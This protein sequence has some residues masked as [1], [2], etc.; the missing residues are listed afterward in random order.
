MANAEF[1]ILSPFQLPSFIAPLWNVSFSLPGTCT[2]PLR[3]AA[4]SPR[5]PSFS[6]PAPPVALFF[7][8]SPSPLL[9]GRLSPSC[10]GSPSGLLRPES[11]CL[12]AVTLFEDRPLYNCFRPSFWENRPLHTYRDI[13]EHN[14]LTSQKEYFNQ[15]FREQQLVSQTALC[16]LLT[17]RIKYT[18]QSVQWHRL[19]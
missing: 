16:H 2:F 19:L 18:L 11:A 15:C 7:P 10:A 12:V 14:L 4:T 9:S 5:L 8:L 3:E 13:R 6:A 17:Q 1:G